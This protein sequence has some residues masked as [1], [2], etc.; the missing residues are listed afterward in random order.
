MITS[1]PVQQLRLQEWQVV[2]LQEELHMSAERLVVG[3]ADLSCRL[4]SLLEMDSLSELQLWQQSPLE[5]V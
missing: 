3:R 1:L 2:I 4:M 5:L